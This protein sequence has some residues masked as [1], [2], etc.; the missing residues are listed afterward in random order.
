IPS[1]PACD[2]AGTAGSICKRLIARDFAIKVGVTETNWTPCLFL[3]ESEPDVDSRSPLDRVPVN[4]IGLEAPV[5]QRIKRGLA[6]KR[7]SIEY[8]KTEHGA[9]TRYMGIDDHYPRDSGC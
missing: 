9:L 8:F 6:K 5:L 3:A 1:N 2:V 7:W 4:P